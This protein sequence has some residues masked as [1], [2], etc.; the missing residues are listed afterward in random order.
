MPD[1]GL[2]LTL[3]NIFIPYSAT[4]LDDTYSIIYLIPTV[5]SLSAA[6]TLIQRAPSSF[7]FSTVLLHVVLGLLF[8]LFPSGAHVISTLQSLSRSCLRIWPVIFHLLDL[9]SSLS[10][11]IRALP[12]VLTWSSHLMR[13]IQRKHLLV[14]LPSVFICTKFNI[15]V[16]IFIVVFYLGHAAFL[17]ASFI[18][19]LLLF[20][21]FQYEVMVL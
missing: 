9:T 10:D 18:L 17:L 12:S 13:T 19:V 5:S 6:T 20:R 2:G 11:F 4:V 15:D 16:L 8:R 14:Y 21:N 3:F 7:T 1:V